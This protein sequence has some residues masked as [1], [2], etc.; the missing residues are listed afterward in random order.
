MVSL[1][2][3]VHCSRVSELDWLSGWSEETIQSLGTQCLDVTTKN[4]YYTENKL[5]SANTHD[6]LSLLFHKHLN[7]LAVEKLQ[8]GHSV[9]FW[10]LQSQ[11]I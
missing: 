5:A 2:L 10:I 9:S 1:C 6:I 7:R 11:F 8:T 3:C 4:Q